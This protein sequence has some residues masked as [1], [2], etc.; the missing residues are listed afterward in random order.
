MKH[1]KKRSLWVLTILVLLVFPL[2]TTKAQEPINIMIV[3]HPDDESIWGGMHLQEG[4]Y[5]VVCLTNKANKTRRKEFYKILKETKNEGIMYSY[6]DKVKGKRSDWKAQ[7][8][9]IKRELKRIL[10]KTSYQ[11]IVTHNPTGEYGHIQHIATS[12][13]VTQVCV[14][15][16]QS[17]KLYYFGT[18][19]KKSQ[20]HQTSKQP[21]L[22]NRITKHQLQQKKDLLSIYRSQDNVRN[23][24]EH[25]FPYENWVSYQD[26]DTI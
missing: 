1:I 15:T 14:E 23:H 5:D 26:W 19:V 20:L 8:K 2:S 3:A 22:S 6:P 17:D 18:Y 13:I 25:M 21:D 7:K 11:R 10:N 4:N 24:L 12:D 9:Q 16:K